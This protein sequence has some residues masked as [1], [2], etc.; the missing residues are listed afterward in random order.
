MPATVRQTVQTQ[1]FGNRCGDNLLNKCLT[2][3]A[4]YSAN[5]VSGAGFGNTSTDIVYSGQRSLYVKNLS[6]TDTL[7]LS[8]GGTNWVNDYTGT[9]ISGEGAVFQFSV[10]NISG[11]PITGRFRVFTGSIEVYVLEFTSIPVSGS[12]AWQTFYSTIPFYDNYDFIFELDS[13]EAEMYLDG[14]KLEIDDKQN[15]DPTP[16]TGYVPKEVTSTN[17]IDIPSIA[18]GTT[19]TVTATL[20]GAIVG[21]YVR[22][23]EPIALINAGLEVGRPVV[24]APNEIKF[25]VR[26]NTG[27]AA[28]P[29][30]GLFNFKI[31]R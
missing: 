5:V 24:T 31:V 9:Y 8:G 22:M 11:V 20:T 3:D 23:V 27:G 2:F 28:N 1:V 30:I 18:D 14:I 6:A 19:T 15:N 21:D 26:N 29:A 17:T 13:P 10:Y 7:V 12:E 16:Y 25:T 4:V